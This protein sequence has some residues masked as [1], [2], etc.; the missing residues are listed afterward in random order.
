[1]KISLPLAAKYLRALFRRRGTLPIEVQLEITNRC[2]FDCEMCPRDHLAAPERHMDEET[3]GIVLERMEGVEEVGLTGWGEPLCFPKFFE[4][5]TKL[6]SRYPQIPV[7]FTTNGVLLTDQNIG[8]IIETGVDGIS[9]SMESV[10][11]STA[12]GHDDPEK[13]A[14]RV[15]EL[16]RK[17]GVSSKPVVAIQAVLD[18]NGRDDLMEVVSFA[19]KA[20]VNYVN[21]VRLIRSFDPKITRPNRK[22]EL[23]LI[24][25]AQRIGREHGVKVLSVN[26]NDWKFKLLTH[27]DTFCFKTAYH[28]YVTVDGDVTPCC[29][30]RDKVMGNLK[31]QSLKEIWSRERFRNF[32]ANQEKICKGCDQ[33]MQG[34]QE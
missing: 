18:L 7:R 21:L 2:N 17:R 10:N 13:V 27:G 31:E 26:D 6:K 32:F 29:L 28:V 22:E 23:G 12:I 3:F 4:Y 34:C 25:E 19:G 24:K 14:S 1:M 8:K 5:V 9:V 11:K 30:L 16:I 15:V 33:L 20:G